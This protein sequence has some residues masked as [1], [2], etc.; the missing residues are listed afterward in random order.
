[1]NWRPTK[2]YPC[3]CGFRDSATATI[4]KR[5]FQQP[6]MRLRARANEHATYAYIQALRELFGLAE[7]SAFAGGPSQEERT[8]AASSD[9]HSQVT[10][11]RPRA[12]GRKRS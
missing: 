1:M 10:P 8:R 3:S 6:V 4:A 7:D 5:L 12:A 2:L 11:L 9:E